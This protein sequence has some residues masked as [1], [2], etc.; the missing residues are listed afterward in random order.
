MSWYVSQ[1]T[2]SITTLFQ[3]QYCNNEWSVTILLHV[4]NA[5][6][7]KDQRKLIMNSCRYIF[8]WRCKNRKLLHF[9]PN[10]AR[11]QPAFFLF[12]CRF[13]AL[14]CS[15]AFPITLQAWKKVGFK[16]TSL[17]RKYRHFRYLSES[18]INKTH[19]SY[20]SSILGLLPTLISLYTSLH[21]IQY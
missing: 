21:V 1:R 8:Y 7:I 10:N 16:T 14:Y 17:S 19:S 11:Y 6:E 2:G 9:A 18:I 4:N 5:I 3:L 20:C 12:F 15:P 13:L